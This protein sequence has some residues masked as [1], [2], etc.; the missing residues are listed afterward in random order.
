MGKWRRLGSRDPLWR[1]PPLGI[2][3]RTLAELSPTCLWLEALPKDPSFRGSS[4]E[5]PVATAAVRR[6]PARPNT[7]YLT[8]LQFVNDRDTL[9]TLLE[10]L[11]ETLRSHGIRTLLGPTHLLPHLGSGALSSHWQLPPPA[12]T[13]YHP[14]YVSEH[15]DALMSPVDTLSLFHFETGQENLTGGATVEV[16]A[17]GFQHPDI[18]P[19]L[20]TASSTTLAPPDTAEAQAILNWLE[21][22]QPFG[23]SATLPGAPESPVGLAL[24]YPNETRSGLRRIRARTG[25]LLG[26]VLP[27]ARRQGVGRTLLGAALAEA[28]TRG[29]DSVSVGPVLQKGDAA[30]FLEACG[31]VRQQGYTLYETKL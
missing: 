7:G 10:H 18:L 1:P 3:R 4:R 21:P 5:V 16:Q 8:L 6:D 28:R 29:W 30:T 12:D 20:Q 9:Y 15:L 23:L 25:R 14:P 19:L 22:Y 2:L 24:L 17:L 31:G 26:G 11:S 27:D 13:P